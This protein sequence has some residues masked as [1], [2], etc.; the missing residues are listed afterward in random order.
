MDTAAE[1]R[2]H[3]P[4]NPCRFLL[5]LAVSL[6]LS[7]L[8]ASLRLS[9][10]THTAT[11]SPSSR[12]APILRRTIPSPATRLHLARLT[13]P[14]TGRAKPSHLPKPRRPSSTTSSFAPF[15]RPLFPV[16]FCEM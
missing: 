3:T 10:H 14:E 5:S 9:L 15:R 4:N 2:A 6:F 1:F 16:S 8:P 11:F 13:S 12:K 7:S